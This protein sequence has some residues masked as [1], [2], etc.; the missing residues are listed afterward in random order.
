[1]NDDDAVEDVGW[2]AIEHASAQSSVRRAA[3]AL[4]ESVGLGEVRTEE[5][6]IVV[7]ELAGNQLK[8]AG[9]G[10]VLLRV[11]RG[12]AAAVEVVASDPGPGMA[13]VPAALVDGHSTVGT[14]G[15][16]LGAVRRLATA[17]DLFSAPGHGTVVTAVFAAGRERAGRL[18]GSAGL[19]RTIV[20]ETL[21]GDAYAFRSDG[22]VQTALLVDGL[23]HGPL[24]ASAAQQA[25]RTF[26]ESRPGTPAALLTAVHHA[27][28][29]T[30]GAAAA[31]AQRH[32]GEIRYAGVGNIRGTVVDLDTQRGMVSYPG[33][34]GAQA[35]T[36]REATYPASPHAVVVMH[37]DG[38]TERL[39]A[40]QYPGLLLCAPLTVAS[41]LLRDFGVRRDDASVLVLRA[42]A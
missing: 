39:T 33:I 17:W 12:G 35:R 21:C 11:R 10:T 16:G 20:G 9:S 19:T 29:G 25:V 8:H 40:H 7:S 31:I 24:A 37:S 6:G 32:P 14:L 4:G 41:V 22:D 5:L 15:I 18:T 27:L 34:V 13:D 2:Y 3:L 28:S 38:L 30:R 42:S 36:I 1:M 23:G 26:R